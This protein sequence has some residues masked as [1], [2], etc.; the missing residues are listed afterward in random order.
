MQKTIITFQGEW[1]RDWHESKRSE[2]MFA[3]SRLYKDFDWERTAAVE[4]IVK[5]E[6]PLLFRLSLNHRLS[7]YDWGTMQERGRNEAVEGYG[8]MAHLFLPSLPYTSGEVGEFGGG[9]HCTVWGMC[10]FAS[11]A[12]FTTWDEQAWA[13]GEQQFTRL[14]NERTWHKRIRDD[15]RTIAEREQTAIYADALAKAKTNLPR[16]ILA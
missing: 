1:Q 11:G 15:L 12:I 6:Q 8:L 16:R 10:Q 14:V 13:W 2:Q 9:S 3:G 5:A 7:T 4:G